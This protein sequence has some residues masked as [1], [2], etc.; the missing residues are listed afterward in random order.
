MVNNPFPAPGIYRIDAEQMSEDEFFALCQSNPIIP[1]E[2]ESDGTIVIMSPVGT[3]GGIL[4]GVLALHLSMWNSTLKTGVVFSPSAGFTLSNRAVRSPDASWIQLA[5]WRSIP[6]AD[7]HRFAHI[8]PDFVA[9]IRSDSDSLSLLEAKMDEY[10]ACGV[11]LAWLIDPIERRASVYR[12]SRL[13][14]TVGFDATLSGEDVLPGFAF[15]LSE[16]S[17]E[18]DA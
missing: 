18:L 12:P 13:P 14:E 7:R 2:R 11:R 4:E 3:T 17:A 15:P 8:V 10:L 1:F 16:L 9:E 6:K 5:R